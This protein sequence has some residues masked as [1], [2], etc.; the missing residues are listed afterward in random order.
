MKEGQAALISSM[1]FQNE[2][3]VENKVTF[4]I[5][6]YIWFYFSFN[7][8]FFFMNFLFLM[9]YFPLDWL[10]LGGVYQRLENEIIELKE[11][12]ARD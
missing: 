3:P 6:I 9:P 10:F 2:I 7:G 8:Y 12:R 5:Y 4:H 11:A 1:V